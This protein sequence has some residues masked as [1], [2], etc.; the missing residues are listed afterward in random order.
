MKNL[1]KRMRST[2]NTI[3]AFYNCSN[4]YCSCTIC[5]CTG[6]DMTAGLRD[7]NQVYASTS[8]GGVANNSWA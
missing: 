6:P 4:C 5:A 1:G 3:M 2:Q 8:Y 7:G